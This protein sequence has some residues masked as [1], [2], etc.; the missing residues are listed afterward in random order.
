MAVVFA[1]LAT[2]LACAGRASAAVT[3]SAVTTPADGSYF[4]NNN[5]NLADPAHQM[6]VSGTTANDGTPGNVDLVCTFGNA[7]GSTA[8]VADRARPIRRL[9]REFSASRSRPR[10]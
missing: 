8:D 5:N 2:L 10:P 4:Q 3:S 9:G 6:T 7:D 1:L